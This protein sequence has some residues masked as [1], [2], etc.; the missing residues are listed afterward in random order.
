ML[1]W[2]EQ[3]TILHYEL[4]LPYQQQTLD[5]VKDKTLQCQY[6]L[7]LLLTVPSNWAEDGNY[8]HRI[9]LLYCYF[10][11]IVNGALGYL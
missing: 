2:Q 5:Y 11:Y 9:I 1:Y 4:M 7:G 8:L 6:L 10:Y 3:K